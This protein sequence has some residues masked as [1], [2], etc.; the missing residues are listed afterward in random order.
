M[1]KELFLYDTYHK[2]GLT[3]AGHVANLKIEHQIIAFGGAKSEGQWRLEFIAAGLPIH[4]PIVSDVEVGISR[5]YGLFK[6]GR[7][8][9]F[10]DLKGIVDDLESYSRVLDDAGEPTEK[11][12][13]KE[14]YHKLDSLR[15]VGSYLNS[16]VSSETEVVI[17]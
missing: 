10:D 17:L 12:E 15:Y 2:G 4:E 3:A 8:K 7:L 16:A 13:D 6:S 9:V 11:I 14:T 1:T 5:V